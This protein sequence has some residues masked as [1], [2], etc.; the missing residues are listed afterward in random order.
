MLPGLTRTAAQPASIAWNTY[1]LWKWMSAITGIGDLA[2]MRGSASASSWLGTATRTMSHPAAVSSAIC[3]SVA[4]T[5]AVFVL[6]IDCTE[7][8]APPP[9]GTGPTMMR[10]DW[11]RGCRGLS[12]IDGSP[13]LRN[14]LSTGA[15]P[16]FNRLEIR[17]RPSSKPRGL[18]AAATITRSV[19][20]QRC[21]MRVSA[22]TRASCSSSTMSATEA[23]WGSPRNSPSISSSTSDTVS[24]I[25]RY[26]K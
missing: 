12:L 17:L 16:H 18:M 5:F 9:T 14:G 6:V 10:R 4:P 23:N 1:R 22:R 20:V 13:V 25:A 7:I 21:A 8:G 2:T 24:T 26:G 15:V 11:R 3:C 19:A